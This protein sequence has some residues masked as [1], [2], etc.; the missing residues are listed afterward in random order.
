MPLAQHP[1]PHTHASLQEAAHPAINIICEKLT[2][3]GTT[4]FE[5]DSRLPL[6]IAVNSASY[7]AKALTQVRMPAAA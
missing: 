2:Y 6:G 7:A 4:R 1:T 3:V 5:D